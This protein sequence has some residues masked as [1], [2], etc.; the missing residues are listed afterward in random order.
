[1]ISNMSCPKCKTIMDF[2]WEGNP[3][4]DVAHSCSNCHTYILNDL[5]PFKDYA[6]AV[7][8]DRVN[9]INMIF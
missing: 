9:R 1:M 4:G 8:W 3:D 6:E 2:H 7:E 5:P